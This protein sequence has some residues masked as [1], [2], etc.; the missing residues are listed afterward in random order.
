MRCCPTQACFEGYTTLLDF[1]SA[2]LLMRGLIQRSV[3]NYS[4]IHQVETCICNA[5]ICSQPF[6]LSICF[7]QALNHSQ[8]V[9]S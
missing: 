5:D 8:G 9:T 4:L 7:L 2:M 1:R 3:C 6:Y